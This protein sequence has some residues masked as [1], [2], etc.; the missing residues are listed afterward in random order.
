MIRKIYVTEQQEEAIKE[1]ISRRI[2]SADRKEPCRY[3]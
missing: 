3:S 1:Y 2:K